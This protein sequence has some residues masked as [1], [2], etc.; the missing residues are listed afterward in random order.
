[1]RLTNKTAIITGGGSG[2]GQACAWAFYQEGANVVLFGRRE[3]KL[4]E[5]AQELGSRAMTVSG[6]MTRSEDLDRLVQETLSKFHRIDI[7]VNNA[8]LFKGAPLHEISDEQYDEMMN[9]NMRAVF[10]LTRR[11]LPVMMEQKSGNIIHISS[12]LGI[13]AVPQVA[14]YN[15]SKGALNQFS[16]SIAVEYGSYGIR[17]NSICPGLIETDMTADLMKD[18]ALMQEWSK[19][20]PIGRFGKPEDVAS[21]CLFLAS[22]ESSFITGT[23]LPVDGGFTAQ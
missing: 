13:I 2:I 12:I 1:M 17:S 11:V 21:A 22:D 5:T 3:D 7:L 16:R 4:K 9:I 10:Q 15:I 20:Y 19:G 6:D 8:G 23:V 14:V 18:E